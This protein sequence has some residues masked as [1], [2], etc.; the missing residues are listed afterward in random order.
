MSAVGKMYILESPTLLFGVAHFVICMHNGLAM[1]GEIDM[2]SRRYIERRIERRGFWNPINGRLY[3]EKAGLLQSNHTDLAEAICTAFAYEAEVLYIMPSRGRWLDERGQYP[4]K[5]DYEKAGLELG[6][7]YRNHSATIILGGGESGVDIVPIGI[8]FPSFTEEHYMSDVIKAMALLKDLLTKHFQPIEVHKGKHDEYRIELQST[9]ARTGMDLLRRKLPYGIK[10]E[11]LSPAVEK[12]I[13]TEFGQAR[14][15]LFDHGRELVENLRN[16]DG[17]WFYAACCRHM[18]VGEVLHDDIDRFIP[19]ITGLYLVEARVPRDWNHIGLLPVRAGDKSV[20][21]NNPGAVVRSWCS[22][23]DLQLAINYQWEILHI[24]ER[25]LWPETQARGKKIG[26]DP[27]RHWM[28]SL[29]RL[30]QEIAND[31]P[32]P[33]SSFLRDAFRAL[34]NHTIGSLHRSKKM[35]D[36][37]TKDFTE[38]PGE[39]AYLVDEDTDGSFHYQKGEELNSY[40]KESFKPHW[41][42]EVWNQAKWK[43]TKA[44]LEVPYEHLV[45][46]RTDGLWTTQECMFDNSGKPGCLR[47][48]ELINRGPFNWPRGTFA[49]VQFVQMIQ[50]ARNG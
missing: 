45:S 8:W 43:I 10:Y 26:Q 40:Q 5:R 14:T 47:E 16:Y 30:R 27:L 28:E 50:R 21:P 15:E 23:R 29:V 19:H 39:G 6:A 9:P 18:P 42:L 32:E 31:Y 7:Y 33:I 13:M 38:D 49:D 44:A 25:I 41:A 4:G 1:K 22:H 36:I 17:L 11:E 48:K 37:Y 35:V 34:L 46:I 12:I 24:R 2:L 3:V 20:Y